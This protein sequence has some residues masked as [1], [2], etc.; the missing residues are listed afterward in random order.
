MWVLESLGI[1]LGPFLGSGIEFGS[2]ALE[3][4]G[5]LGDKGVV[6]VCVSKE[7]RDRQQDL[8][9]CEG[10]RPLILEDVETNGAVGV[11][12][13]VVDLGD[14]VAF[15]RPEG[16]VGGEV[17]IEEE[18]AS[19]VGTVVGADDGGLPVKLIVFVGASRAV[20]GGILLQ[21]SELLLDS[22]QGHFF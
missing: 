15:G 2:V 7:G 12:V 14:E 1:F 19:R 21:V 20:G 6:R 22:F 8:R 9:D 13:G 3:K 16:V 10:G 11:D 18:N 17:D 4:L 5:D